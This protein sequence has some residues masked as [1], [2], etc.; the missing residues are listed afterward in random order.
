MKTGKKALLLAL[1]AVLL[2][3]ATVMGTMAYLTAKATVTN[4]FTMGNV[5]MTMD[6]AKVNVNGEPV[7]EDGKAVDLKDARRV[8]E[9]TYKLMPGHAYTKDPTVHVAAN[10]E[11]SWIFVKVDNQISAF[12]SKATDY[13][14]IAAQIEAKGWKE[15]EAGVYYKEYTTAATMTDYVVFENF[16]IDSGAEKVTSWGSATNE[17]VVITAYA[18][19][20]DGFP[21]A[22][23]AWKVAQTL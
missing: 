11:N 18:I 7:D 23:D 16:T 2:V 13:V 15:L 6:E 3:A 4:T 1:C 17:Q 8:I 10:S 14:N 20:K 9:N 12:E 22:A 5:A 21:T 19:Q